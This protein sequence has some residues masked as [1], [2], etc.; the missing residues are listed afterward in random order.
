MF[1]KATREKTPL[2]LA[3]TGPSG[4]GKT[5]SALLIA[6][7]IGGRVA[8][9]D[10]EN[11]TASLYSDRFEFDA[12]DVEPPYT[13]DKYILAIDAAIEQGYDVLV[14]DS[15]THQWA[16]EGGALDRKTQ[17]D[18]RGGNSYTNW[19]K[20]TPDQDRFVAKVLSA[21]IHIIGTMRSKTAYVMEENDKGKQAPKK[22]GMA[23]VQRDGFEYEFTI[24]FDLAMN[25][26]AEVSKDRTGLFDGQIFKPDEKTGVR[27]IEWLNAG[28]DV[29][30]DKSAG[31][32]D[33]TELFDEAMG[34]LTRAHEV[35]KLHEVWLENSQA[36]K[37]LLASKH[38]LLVVEHKDKLKN[39]PPG[40]AK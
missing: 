12:C 9:I 3:V 16:G 10:T 25:H 28:A 7:G 15:L 21:P 35:G 23:P 18:Q 17:I 26:S 30:P 13:V 24:M 37:H 27:I 11:K 5:H 19:G 39:T 20:V 36:W 33:T 38:W 40:E 6:K 29:K 2:K 22:V 31:S 14:I 1:Q 8:V 4:S 32:A 34:K